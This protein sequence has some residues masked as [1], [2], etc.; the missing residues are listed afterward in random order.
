MTR[1]RGWDA[2]ASAIVFAGMLVAGRADAAEETVVLVPGWQAGE[3]VRYDI[4]RTRRKTQPDKP[5]SE[6][7]ARSS[8]EIEVVSASE[9][10]YVV[11]W[12][13]GGTTIDAASPEQDALAKKMSD[14]VKGLR[15]E[16]EMDSEAT[17]TGVRNWKD[18]QATLKKSAD[19]I[20][21]EMKAKGLDA[22]TVAK[23]RTQMAQIYGG[24]MLVEQHC[25][26]D[27]QRFFMVLGYGFEDGKPV[28]YE[29]KLPNPFGGEPFPCKAR[30]S[31]RSV[32]RKLGV[33]TVDF[34]QTFVE[35]DARRIMEKTLKD[36]AERMGK[37]VPDGEGLK[38]FSVE[39]TAEFRVHLASGW[40]ESLTHKRATKS[41]GAS[42]D[43][44][45]TFTRKRDATTPSPAATDFPDDL[46]GQ[47]LRN[48]V[49]TGDDL[50]KPRDI[51]FFFVFES[52]K[53]AEAF[54]ADV[55]A[56]HALEAKTTEDEEGGSWTSTVTKNMVPT[57]DGI[58]KL[59]RALIVLAEKHD[60]EPEGWGCESVG[61]GR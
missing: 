41:G 16:I 10:A 13:H 33:A 23:I 47:V 24:K 25:T 14:L 27:P 4:V 11:A 6:T 58:T 21:E 35:E 45:V 1:R 15:V 37:P 5:V 38:S 49:K 30:Y 2:V 53:K 51:E 20:C 39:D 8:A 36:M 31:L 7:V 44:I 40:I 17:I 22:D 46:N 60:G 12:T 32:D 9:E 3:K 18:L 29:D 28:E 26:R 50:T 34:K 59:E 57:H 55:R 52:A 48:L 42:Q 54:A 56:A 43:D 61:K 19:L